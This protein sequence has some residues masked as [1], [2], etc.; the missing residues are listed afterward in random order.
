MDTKMKK[1]I[2][3]VL[4]TVLAVYAAYAQE[5]RKA[6]AEIDSLAVRAEALGAD[7]TQAQWDSLDVRFGDIIGRM[8]ENRDSL[9][10]EELNHGMQALGRYVGARA[11]FLSSQAG[12]VVD[13]VSSYVGIIGRR[14]GAFL[15]GF[16]QGIGTTPPP[17][18]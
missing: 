9:S 18:N 14:I 4:V 16:H 8:H 7:G 10:R 5:G 2:L 1:W 13:S 11:K 12:T 3:S 15:R 6:L 17:Q